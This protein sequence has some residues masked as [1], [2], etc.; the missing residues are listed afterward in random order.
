MSSHS[1]CSGVNGGADGAPVPVPLLLDDSPPVRAVDP[2]L[3]DGRP[4]ALVPVPLDPPGVAIQCCSVFW[5]LSLC[6]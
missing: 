6:V 4:P 3:D 5:L 2:L 1:S